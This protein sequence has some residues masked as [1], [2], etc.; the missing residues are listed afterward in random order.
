MTLQEIPVSHG[1][2]SY[3]PGINMKV[4]P[5]DRDSRQVGSSASKNKHAKKHA[6]ADQLSHLHTQNPHPQWTSP[7][8]LKRQPPK[9]KEKQGVL[10]NPRLMTTRIQDKSSNNT[11]RPTMKLTQRRAQP[12]THRVTTILT[13]AQMPGPVTLEANNS[14]TRQARTCTPTQG[15]T[16]NLLKLCARVGR[17]RRDIHERRSRIVQGSAE[18]RASHSNSYITLQIHAVSLFEVYSCV[19]SARKTVS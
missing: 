6:S 15:R 5:S 9:R 8:V 12:S 14:L 4:T 19:T 18:T 3:K 11:S 13:G 10:C 16:Q 1:P 17:L 2:H 7:A